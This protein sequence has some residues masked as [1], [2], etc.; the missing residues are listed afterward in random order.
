MMPQTIIRFLE[1]DTSN[2]S[3]APYIF[4]DS[5]SSSVNSGWTET[6]RTPSSMFVSYANSN[7]NRRDDECIPS[8]PIKCPLQ[9]SKKANSP[10]KMRE[11]NS[12]AYL[13]LTYA[14][15]HSRRSD[16]YSNQ[17]SVELAEAVRGY[18]DWG[19]SEQTFE[20]KCKERLEKEY[21]VPQFHGTFVATAVQ[22]GAEETAKRSRRAVHKS[23]CLYA[24]MFDRLLAPKETTKNTE[25]RDDSKGQV[26]ASTDVE[27]LNSQVQS[28]KLE[29]QCQQE[30]LEF[31]RCA[32]RKLILPS[33]PREESQGN[34]RDDPPKRT[35]NQ[36]QVDEAVLDR[37][38]DIPNEIVIRVNLSD[39]ASD[40]ISRFSSPHE[41]EQEDDEEEDGSNSNHKSDEPSNPHQQQ[42]AQPPSQHIVVQNSIPRTN[43]VERRRSRDQQSNDPGRPLTCVEANMDLVYSLR[44]KSHFTTPY[45]EMTKGEVHDDR[46]RGIECELRFKDWNRSLKGVYCGQVNQNEIPHGRGVLRFD[47]RDLYIGE[48]I[49][50]EMHGEGTLFCRS[51]TKLVTLRGFFRRN[52]YRGR[53]SISSDEETTSAGAA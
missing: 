28:L 26:T 7:K 42:P 6:L 53:H 24:S 35:T 34:P 44:A 50:G 15:D 52:E 40:A 39:D 16:Q 49:D 27:S 13:F 38:H 9:A 46:A 23:Y 32:L 10:E 48:F 20:E 2:N 51:K 29:S 8:R 11:T 47:N 25:A 43:G 12:S 31:L 18:S 30:E 22:K 19:K 3:S 21:N 41:E 36:K 37:D 17:D 33:R 45:S 14:S 4:L 5:P 1:E